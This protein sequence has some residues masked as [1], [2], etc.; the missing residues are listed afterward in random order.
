[1]KRAVVFLVAALA[2]PGAALAKP[3]HP[4]HPAHPNHGK[5]APKV[6]YVLKGNLSGY[7][8]YDSTTSTNGS[9]TIDV[10]RANRHGR[11]LKGVT[12]TFSVSAQTKI[13]FRH[14]T[15]AISDGDRG[16]VKIKAPKRIAA[17]DLASTLQALNARQVIDQGAPKSS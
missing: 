15:T 17:A 11:A 2:V 4:A 3:P 7:S 14:G 13:V 12:L 9:I 16:I 6:M 1:M 8:A 10:K 5:S